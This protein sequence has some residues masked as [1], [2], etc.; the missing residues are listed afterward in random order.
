M[1]DKLQRFVRDNHEA[2]DTE[3]PSDELWHKLNERLP[4]VILV[5]EKPSDETVTKAAIVHKD[6]EN[7]GKWPTFS[8]FRRSE[9]AWRV[10]A[11]VVLAVGLGW[12]ANDFN[13]QYRLTENPNLALSSPN[14]AKQMS[15]YTQLIDSKR[16]E[17]QHIAQTN[18]VLYKEFAAELNQ[19]EYSYQ[20][21]KADLPQNPNQE[22]VVRAM[23]QNLQWQIELLNQQLDIIQR[24]KSK[25][26][27][28]SA[29]II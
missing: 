14:Y 8:T 23:I 7:G 27:N 17:L 13:Q 6:F 22:M 15:Q 10:A 19:L 3:T 24:I 1:K 29:K 11:A 25:N 9:G 28:E 20:N 26:N 4:K 2:F 18:P 12:Y 21:L 5:G 16:A